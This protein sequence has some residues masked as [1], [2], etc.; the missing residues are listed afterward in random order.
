MDYLSRK[1]SPIAPELWEQIDAATV[2]VARNVL[3]GRRILQLVGPLGAGV[4]SIHI[5]DANQRGEHIQDGFITTAGRKLAEI[6]T[7]YQDFTLLARDLAQGEQSGF[8][9]DLSAVLTAAQTAALAEDRLVFLGNQKLGIDGLLSAPGASHIAKSDWSTGENA[10]ADVASA[11]DTLVAN[12]VF[13]NYTLVLS[14]S[15]HTQLQRLQPGTGLLEV[16][17]I[18]KLVG[19]QLFKTP[20][21]GKHQAVLLCAQPENVDLVIGQDLAAAY[22]EQH[23]LNHAFRLL[24]TV[25]PR[26]KKQQSIVVLES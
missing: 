18:S 3:V 4:T 10:F 11:I 21:L 26:I 17:R 19:G 12:G 22:L 13:G 23:D 6:P 8:G 20:V 7:L 15:L 25:L 2:K 14:P 1:N 5:D 16:D 24:E 9:L